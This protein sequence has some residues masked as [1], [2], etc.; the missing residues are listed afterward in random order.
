MT[1]KTMTHQ[2]CSKIWADV[3][4]DKYNGA[5]PAHRPEIVVDDEAEQVLSIPIL[6]GTERIVV[7]RKPSSSQWSLR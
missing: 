3:K 1:N 5:A 7:S 2:A 4:T 6:D